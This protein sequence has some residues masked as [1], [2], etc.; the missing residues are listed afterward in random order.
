M[1]S[2]GL[3]RLP[4]VS[5][6]V[7]VTVDLMYAFVPI[8]ANKQDISDAAVGAPLA[9]R[10]GAIAIAVGSEEGQERQASDLEAVR[11]S[12]PSL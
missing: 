4:A 6:A 8:R 3:W 9:L 7:L 5:G 1:S 12:T 10:A 11:P 2:R